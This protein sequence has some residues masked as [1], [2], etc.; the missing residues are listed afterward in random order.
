MRAACEHADQITGVWGASGA[1]G[2]VASPDV[3]CTPLQ[4]FHYSHTHGTNDFSAEPI[5][6]TQ[7]PNAGMASSCN[8][9]IDTGGTVD[10]FLAALGCAGQ[11]SMTTTIGAYDFDTGIVGNES[12]LL[13]GTGCFSGGSFQLIRMNGSNHAPP[14]NTTNWPAAFVAWMGAHHR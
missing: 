10:Q 14:M 9:T 8:A 2:F 1:P 11:G 7:P 3:T 12:D 4:P 13:V 6:G 5:T